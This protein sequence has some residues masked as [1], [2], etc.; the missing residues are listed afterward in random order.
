[1]MDILYTQFSTPVNKVLKRG[2]TILDE[3]KKKILQA[4]VEEYIETAEPV[5]SKALVE[6]HNLDYS[7]ATIRN[8][9]AE[10]E[11]ARPIR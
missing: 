11:K 3:R 2:D 9:M 6:K 8:D 1:M 4:I 7:S 5:S 10:L